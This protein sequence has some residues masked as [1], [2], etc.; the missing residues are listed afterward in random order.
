MKTLCFVLSLYVFSL[1]VVPC[2]SDD[3][4]NDDEI[5]ENAD[6]HSQEPIEE[7]NCNACSPFLNCG[8]CIGFVF[9]NLQLDISEISAIEDHFVPVYKPQFSDNF[10]DK[11]WQPPK[12]S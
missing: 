6:N 11:I 8:T 1:S 12:I 5:T 7:G 4:C 9:T 10:F 3:N 2:C